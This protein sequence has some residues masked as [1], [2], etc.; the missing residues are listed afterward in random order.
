MPFVAFLNAE[1]DILRPVPKKCEQNWKIFLKFQLSIQ[2]L[3]KFLKKI[4]PLFCLFSF[5]SFFEFCF[6][7]QLMAKFG[8]TNFDGPGNPGM[9]G[10]LLRCGSPGVRER[11]LKLQNFSLIQPTKTEFPLVS[12]EFKKNIFQFL[13]NPEICRMFHVYDNIRLSLTK[14]YAVNPRYTTYRV[15]SN[16]VNI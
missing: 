16:T 12:W 3:H 7:E 6:Y 4:W 15:I 9:L 14:I 13:G 1:E 10:D 8:F 11:I 2:F 5:F